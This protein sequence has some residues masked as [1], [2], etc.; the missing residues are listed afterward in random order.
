V[1]A[2]VRLGLA[3][4]VVSQAEARGESVDRSFG[5]A[6]GE[7]LRSVARRAGFET[8]LRLE[9]GRRA[10][11]ILEAAGVPVLLFKGA[12]LVESGAYAD[13]RARPMSDVDLLVPPEGAGA[14][15][16]ALEAGGFRSWEPWTEEHPVWVSAFAL[17]D[18][19]APPGVTATVDLHWATDYGRLRH[20][21]DWPG[22]T[23]WEDR[24]GE[25]RDG[26]LPSPEAHF[27]L[28]VEHFLKH[29]RVTVHLLSVAD[30][31]RLLPRLGRP[32]EIVRQAERR[33]TLPGVRAMVGALEL[34]GASVPSELADALGGAGRLRI[35]AR[36]A[37][38]ELRAI[39]VR[40]EKGGRWR[41]WRTLRGG[42]G[43]VAEAARVLAP[44]AAW[45]R[46]RYPAGSGTLARRARYLRDCLRWVA[47]GGGS[48]L[49]P[50]QEVG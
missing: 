38:L 14:A 8:T 12:A 41:D 45:L 30:L 26:A 15:V 42:W 21:P 40:A 5:A 19:D 36:R 28:T 44:P 22:E 46:A 23:L 2:L 1:A 9:S 10:R 27:V 37:H 48:P 31:V 25:D 16:R 34:L 13:V 11:G 4:L 18:G 43:T 20:A 7:A 32:D 3:G 49:S 33:G 50:N 29:L 39:L 6:S 47:S 24:S 17:D 35:E